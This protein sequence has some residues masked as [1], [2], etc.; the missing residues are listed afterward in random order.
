VLLGSLRIRGQD[1]ELLPRRCRAQICPPAG[2]LIDDKR[3]GALLNI[4]F[5]LALLEGLRLAGS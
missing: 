2:K 4:Q 3:I 1:F 5:L